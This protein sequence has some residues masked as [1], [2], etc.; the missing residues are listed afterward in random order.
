[1]SSTRHRTQ[2]DITYRVTLKSPSGD[3]YLRTGRMRPGLYRLRVSA[4][5]V[6][7]N[8]TARDFP[9]RVLP[10]PAEDELQAVGLDP[11]AAHDD[12]QPLIDLEN[13]DEELG[14]CGC[15]ELDP[16]PAQPPD[17]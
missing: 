2:P 11:A 9:I 16:A 15:P 13:T 4:A 17:D 1:V 6:R 12:D 10:P 3:G 5:D 14:G 8:E 7:G